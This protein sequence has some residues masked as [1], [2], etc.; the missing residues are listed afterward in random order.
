M[1]FVP[2]VSL[3]VPPD[4]IRR[5]FN[6][7]AL[8][9]LSESIRTQGLF[10]PLLVRAD[11]VTLIAGERRKR[12][13]EALFQT[14]GLDVVFDGKPLA[15]DCAPV[16]RLS[17]DD[18]GATL[19]AELS[20][21]TRRQQLTWQEQ[22]AATRALHE[23]RKSQNPLHTRTDTAEEIKGR[24][25]ETVNEDILISSYLDDEE[26]VKAPTR[27]EALRVVER[28]LE[29]LHREALAKRFGERVDAAIGRCYQGDMRLIL[30][31][32]PERFDCLIADPPYGINADQ[33]ANQSAVPHTYEDSVGYSDQ[34]N[35]Y[36]ASLF[37]THMKDEA[38]AYI[39]LDPRRFQ[40]M[41]DIYQSEGWRVWPW[42]LIWNRGSSVGLLPWPEHGPRRTY[43]AILYAIKGARRSTGVFPDVINV[44]HDGETERGAHKP[45]GLYVDLIRRSCT[46][47]D[48][49][50]DPACGTGPVFEAARR[51]NTRAV[52]IELEAGA[53]SVAVGRLKGD[54]E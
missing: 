13:L 4:R 38:H 23:L 41:F 24:A 35:R 54:T 48:T 28:K 21:N 17:D 5:E 52:G 31:N 11:G 16:V 44:P 33:M 27:R 10:H 50:L 32:L 12:V 14:E 30:P 29:T 7:D 43:E 39:F 51:T 40:A 26:V 22:A 46:P 42:P 20:E 8:S 2:L 37:H 15:H 9:E 34:L 3:I 25:P 36:I 18:A 19:E 49:V 45:F 6:A 53:Y 47:G 1:Q